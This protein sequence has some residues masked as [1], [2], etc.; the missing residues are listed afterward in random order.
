MLVPILTC[1]AVTPLLAA[2]TSDDPADQ[3]SSGLDLSADLDRQS[4]AI[5]FPAD[6]L[7]MTRSDVETLDSAYSFAVAACAK[8]LG[9]D[10]SPFAPNDEPLYDAS[11]YFGVWL[12]KY[13]QEF[14][15]VAP[16][17]P[18]DM[19]ANGVKGAPSVTEHAPGAG[20]ES[21]QLSDDDRAQLEPCFTSEEASRFDAVSLAGAAP[22]NGPLG[23]IDAEF[24]GYPEAE[25][26]VADYDDCLKANGL[27]PQPD[28]PGFA[29]GADSREISAEQIEL[30]LK[31]V[32]CKDEVDY[33]QRL[34]D[35]MADK[36]APII[37]DYA[38]EMVAQ[39]EKTDQVVAE[40]EAYISEHRSEFGQ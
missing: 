27:Q 34:A 12:E 29:R 28:T 39:K 23:Q 36:Q 13:A 9:V 22:W 7:K 32:A 10:Y 4:G 26:V 37:E 6:R 25:E 17:T 30:A 24:F 14:G 33:V 15:F 2:C 21:A 1:L 40:A 11:N 19:A 5:V 8:D 18:A 31:V 20:P 38:T 35:V 3:A 16:M